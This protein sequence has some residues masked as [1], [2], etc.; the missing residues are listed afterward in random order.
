MFNM[1]WSPYYLLMY[2]RSIYGND[3]AGIIVDFAIKIVNK[4]WD[5]NE[6]SYSSN[7][8]WETIAQ[9]DKPWDL[10]EISYG[11]NITW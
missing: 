1:N 11:T 4:P 3:I 8:T 5:L 9:Q 6:I 10:N 2:T 7:I